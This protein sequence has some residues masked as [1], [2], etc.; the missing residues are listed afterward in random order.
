[1]E[2]YTLTTEAAIKAREWLRERG[3]FQV[4]RSINLSDPGKT[5]LT[6]VCGPNGEPVEKP[7]WSLAN[8]P[9][10]VI[11]EEKECEV[12]IDKEVKRFHVGVRRSSNG[13][14]FKV[15]DGGS[16]RIHAAMEKAG[17]NAYHVFDYETQEA[18]IMAPEKVVPMEQWQG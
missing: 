3:G 11:T 18:V 14:S 16:R 9:E 15:T 2:R 4:F 17:E 8:K 10:R 1:M 6:P 13:P 7:H 5:M 12:A